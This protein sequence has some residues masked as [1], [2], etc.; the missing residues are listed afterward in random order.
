ME[1]TVEPLLLLNVVLPSRQFSDSLAM[2][3]L[4]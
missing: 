4:L 3:P 2:P 1:M